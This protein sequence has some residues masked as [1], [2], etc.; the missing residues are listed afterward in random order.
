MTG[1]LESC[2]YWTRCWENG[3][4]WHYLSSWCQPD[5]INSSSKEWMRLWALSAW[6]VSLSCL[7]FACCLCQSWK[8]SYWWLR[9]QRLNRYYCCFNGKC[10]D[11]VEP[12]HR[13]PQSEHVFNQPR[14]LTFWRYVNGSDRRGDSPCRHQWVLTLFQ[15]DVK[16]VCKTFV[17]VM[18]T[19]RV[20]SL[21]FIQGWHKPQCSTRLDDRWAVCSETKSI[22]I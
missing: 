7:L 20:L 5:S 15:H 11:A 16:D 12:A 1:G 2:N 4:Y 19:T 14:D 6:T 10:A 3:I 21:C 13:L 22:A 9:S 17:V 18:K 8:P